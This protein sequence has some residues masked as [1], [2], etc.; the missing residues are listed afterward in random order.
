ML[1]ALQVAVRQVGDKVVMPFFHK[2]ARLPKADGST[3][4]EADIA[5]QAALEPA[6]RAILDVPL[7]GE[8]MTREE[9]Q[10]SWDC[11]A[12]GVWVVDPIDG[13]ANFANGMPY[14]AL[15]VALV[16]QGRPV[17][18]AVY[19]PM[20][21][22][23][24]AA[25][26]GKGAWRNGERLPLNPVVP[27]LKEA[28]AG[29]DFKRLPTGF[30]QIIA[31]EHPFYSQRNLGSAA[32]EICYVASGCLDIYL[33]GGL[34]LWDFAAPSLILSEAGGYAGRLEMPADAD[35]WSGEVF[36]KSVVAAKTP[37]LFQTWH[38]WLAAKL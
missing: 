24:F 37:E 9:Q 26:L 13:T 15:A 20:L 11:G 23:M 16:K 25:E 4:T 2:A 19:A 32:L 8:E 18:A 31:R 30:G 29:V 33:H 6:L 34:M 38:A 28:L 27:E 21:G 14:F 3:L 1:E 10:A 22:E 7:L 35:F 5:A 36:R 12:E 17:L